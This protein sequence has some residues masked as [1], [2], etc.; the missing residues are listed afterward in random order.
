MSVVVKLKEGVTVTV[1]VT[2]TMTAAMTLGKSVFIQVRD[3]DEA[4]YS[5]GF[6][7]CL[8]WFSN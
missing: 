2:P 4:I 5:H 7:V 6:T 3:F 1:S 8:V